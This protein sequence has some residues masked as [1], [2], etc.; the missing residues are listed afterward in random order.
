MADITANK[1]L[2]TAADGTPL[3]AK[4]RQTQQRMKLRALGL[5]VPLLAFILVTFVLPI[6]MMLYRSIDNP[7]MSQIMPKTT[8][9]LRAWDGRELPSDEIWRIV[10]EEL[11][12]GHKNKEIG[13]VA[14]RLNYDLPGTRS[15][16]TSTARK[17]DRWDGDGSVRDFMIGANRKWGDIGTWTTI[18]MASPRFTESFYLMA[19]DM[20]YDDQ[21]SIVRQQEDRQIYVMLF[22]RT[23]WVSLTITVLCI[24][25]AYPIS[26][27]MA[28]L[29]LRHSNLLMILVLLPFWTSLLVRTTSWIVLLQ[30]Q[31]VL[32]DIMVALGLLGDEDRIQMIYNMTGTIVA[33]THI[34]LP[35]MVLPLYSV[36]KTI[37]PSYVRAAQSLGATPARAFWKVYFPQSVPGIGAGSILVFILAV[38]YYITPAL[39]GGRTGQLISNF[40]AYWMQEVHWSLAAALGG[41]LLAG[42]L[43]LY[44]LYNWLIGIDNM[45]LG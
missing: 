27:L 12:A 7:V 31:G 42:V 23:L 41:L 25:L 3:K 18:K 6:G 5:V 36:M 11:V 26:Y 19:L 17:L 38:G 32:N 30:T 37:S 16:I 4:L 10:A 24:L 43:A 44:W 22:G 8:Q 15:M 35:F 9:A 21:G 1:P 20:R 45:K 2:L 13:R 33:M 40:I 29:P 39:V 34:L 28:T 14:T